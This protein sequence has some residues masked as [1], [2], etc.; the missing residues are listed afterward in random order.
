MCMCVK[1]RVVYH[2]KATREY[3]EDGRVADAA[4]FIVLCTDIINPKIKWTKQ[5]LREADAD[6]QKGNDNIMKLMCLKTADLPRRDHT[7]TKLRNTSDTNLLFILSP[8]AL[9]SDQLGATILN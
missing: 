1:T 7:K 3:L 9:A 5:I 4:A 6:R 2:L 8:N